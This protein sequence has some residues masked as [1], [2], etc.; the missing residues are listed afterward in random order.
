MQ[1][2]YS[3]A[4]RRR[5]VDDRQLELPFPPIQLELRLE[6]ESSKRL[7]RFEGF[8]LRLQQAYSSSHPKISH[9][10]RRLKI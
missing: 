3:R 10:Q 7:E 6:P 2:K 8:L 4:A 9:F 5:Q 1:R